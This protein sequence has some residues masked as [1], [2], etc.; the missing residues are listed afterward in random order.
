MQAHLFDTR[1][2]LLV[3]ALHEGSPAPALKE[4]IPFFVMAAAKRVP[5]SK[6]LKLRY[7]FKRGN[8]S[9]EE[10]RQISEGAAAIMYDAA[11][12]DNRTYDPGDKIE[13]S[14]DPRVRWARRKL[15]N[16]PLA[17]YLAARQTYLEAA[18]A[19]STKNLQE[20]RTIPGLEEEAGKASTRQEN[21]ENGLFLT[22]RVIEAAN[23]S[24]T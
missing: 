8:L 21:L 6:Y 9:K 10:Y 17:E 19:R 15:T 23:I 24:L 4:K 5:V 3:M 14:A 1:G 7:Q 22:E 2:I 13:F 18:V 20:L 12:S 16:V 11:K